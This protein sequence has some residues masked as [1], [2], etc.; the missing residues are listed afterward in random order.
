MRQ[1]YFGISFHRPILAISLS[2]TLSLISHLGSMILSCLYD[3]QRQLPYL[4]ATR[5]TGMVN[6]SE[7]IGIA[8]IIAVGFASPALAQQ[9]AVTVYDGGLNAFDMVTVDGGGGS[10]APPATGGGSFGYNENL[11]RNQW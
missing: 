4:P 8:A 9:G 1:R 2:G 5:R 10:F 7:L 11:H 3:K 6:K